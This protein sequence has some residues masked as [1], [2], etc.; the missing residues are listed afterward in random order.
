VRA[1]ALEA[2]ARGC[3][4]ARL[5]LVER[6]DAPLRDDADL[7]LG[8]LVVCHLE[9]LAYPRAHAHNCLGRREHEEEGVAK[10]GDDR[11][12]GLLVNVPHGHDLVLALRRQVALV[13]R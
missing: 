11:G 5:T 9:P 8:E 1:T 7:E 6:L 10:V 12:L 3:G 4:R 2:A 13:E